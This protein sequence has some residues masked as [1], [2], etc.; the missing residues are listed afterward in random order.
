MS[1]TTDQLSDQAETAR[2]NICR[3]RALL[4]QSWWQELLEHEDYRVVRIDSVNPVADVVTIALDGLG[5]SLTVAD[6]D[7]PTLLANFEE[8]VVTRQGQ[9]AATAVHNSLVD[10]LQAMLA[11]DPDRGHVLAKPE[12]RA[13]G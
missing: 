2:R 11:V 1:R 10:K 5:I 13:L 3:C 6:I 7:W 9:D 4:Q 8:P 12:F